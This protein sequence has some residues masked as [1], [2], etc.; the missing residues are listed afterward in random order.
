MRLW[1]SKRIL[2]ERMDRRTDGRMNG[3]M[4]RT[5]RWMYPKGLTAGHLRRWVW[6][7]KCI[8]DRQMDGQMERQMPD[9]YIF[10][11]RL[12]LISKQ[13]LIEN[14]GFYLI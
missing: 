8:W 10:T 2:D 11:T 7:V 4:Y 1:I 12:G 9:N 6:T 3:K 5:A 14:I 13:K